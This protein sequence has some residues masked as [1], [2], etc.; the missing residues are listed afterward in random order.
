MDRLTSIKSFVEVAHL[1][2][3][4][5]A[6]ERLNLSRL[7]VSRHVQELEQWL[8]QRLLHR[9]T[10]KVSLTHDGERAL[11]RFERILDETAALITQSIDNKKELSG[12]IRISSPIGFSQ[13]MLVD[14]VSSFLSEHPGVTIDI[15]ASDSFTDLVEQRIDIALRYTNAPDE[16]LIA[17]PLMKIGSCLCAAPDYFTQTQPPKTPQELR[18][19]NCLVHLKNDSWQLIKS[20]VSEDIKV[21]GALVC[22]DVFT[23]LAATLN[24]TGVSLLPYDLARTYIND[25]RL[26]RI[27]GDYTLPSIQLW[28]VYLSRSYQTPL[29]RA[30]IDFVANM[31]QEDITP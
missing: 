8:K 19:H 22:N 27:L 23:I 25:K 18:E 21:N 20:D 28:A 26:V 31:W 9:T 24:G 29:V 16:T 3:F 17:R 4:T 11:I 6:A 30:F 1:S 5:K 10:R 15:H 13:T 7:Q 12:T 2:S 14:A